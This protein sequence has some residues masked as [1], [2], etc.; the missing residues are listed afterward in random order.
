M[1][2][3]ENAAAAVLLAGLVMYA[4][5]GGADFGGGVWTVL[6]RG[7]RAAEQREALFQAVGP[8]WET[9]HIWL[10]L[11]V[12]VLFT[13][14]PTAFAA[15]FIALFAPLVLALAGVTFRGA[16]FA[17]RHFGEQHGRYLPAT[18]AVFGLTS[19]LTPFTLGMSLTA[20]ASGRIHYRDGEVVAGLWSSWIS[21]FTLIGGVTAVAVCAFVTPIFMLTRTAGE[22][23]EDF[24]RYALVATVV[25]GVLTAIAL[26]VAALDAPDFARRLVTGR[27]IAIIL[28]AVVAGSGTLWLLWTRRF[29]P[30]QVA[31]GLVVA[32]TL[33][34]FGAAMYPYLIPGDLSIDQAAA[35]RAT[36]VALLAALPVGAALLIPSLVLLYRTFRG[37]PNPNAPAG[38][39]P[40][41]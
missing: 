40:A 21:P 8:V 28:A 22:L 7:P 23:R 36:L 17:F 32:L 4:V 19:L 30:A 13:A 14:F 18:T 11:V 25:L 41:H 31:A 24:R 29:W 35:P 20:V 9:N 2:T 39:L 37:A 1:F 6:V 15:L 26:P 12:V 27:E 16:A 33:T 38:E 10:I 34:G 3:L 5:F